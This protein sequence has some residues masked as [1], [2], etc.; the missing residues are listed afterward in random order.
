MQL[1]KYR[2]I[3]RIL[4][5]NVFWFQ[6]V[7]FSPDSPGE[8]EVEVFQALMDLYKAT[9]GPGWGNKEGW[10]TSSHHCPAR[11]YDGGW[12]GDCETIDFNFRFDCNHSWAVVA[13]NFQN[14]FNRI[15]WTSV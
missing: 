12:N 7:P 13:G 11:N 10:G 8:P 14:W 4:C 15:D 5:H 1:N 2:P 3:L 9:N 6:G